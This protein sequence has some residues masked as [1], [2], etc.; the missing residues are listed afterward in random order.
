MGDWVHFVTLIIVVVLFVSAI[1]GA[2]YIARAV[3]DAIANA[4]ES[5]K[6]KGLH[7]TDSGVAVKTSKRVD[8]ENYLDRTQAAL[9]NSMKYTSVGN[10]ESSRSSSMHETDRPA[11]SSEKPSAKR[12][13]STN[14]GLQKRK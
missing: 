9:V 2:I 3:S 6:N 5:L 4:K 1:V 13:S 10:K 7:V 14:S 11:S 12:S 8:R